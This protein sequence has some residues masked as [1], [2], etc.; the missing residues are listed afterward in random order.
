[1]LGISTTN[2]RVNGFRGLSFV[3]KIIAAFKARVLADSGTFEAESCLNTTVQDLVNKNL[4]DSASL[5]VTPN[6]VKAS[7]LYSIVP[8]SALGDMDV[9]RATTATRVNASGLIE[10]V[11]VNIPRIDYTNGSCPSLLVEPQ[12]TNSITYS[13]KFDDVSWLLT[14]ATI[15]GGILSPSGINNAWT[16]SN[17]APSGILQK[18]VSLSG[19]RTLTLY[20][21]Q[22]THRYLYMGGYGGVN[23]YANFDLLNGVVSSG[24]NATIKSVGNGWYCCTCNLI[25]G[26]TG[27]LQIF[28]SNNAVGNSTTNGS[29]YIWGAQLEAGSFATSYIP[30]VA[31]S[32]TRNTDMISKTEISSLIG[33]TEGTA[34][35]EGVLSPISS[36]NSLVSLEVKNS[37]FINLR[38][39]NLNKIEVGTNGLSTEFTIAS[40]N[41]ILSNT[42]YKVAFSYKSG[43][44]NLYIN[45]VLVA[46]NSVTYTIPALSQFKFNVWDTFD[47][48]KNIKTSV[49]WK[50]QLTDFELTTLTTS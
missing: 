4:Y 33:Q 20:A 10:S 46:S 11:G 2:L 13:E 45:G 21:K 29:I 38:V 42:F 44:N 12:R 49:I 34:Y 17:T 25:S 28:P 31:A 3:K 27:G 30:T 5:I 24:A 47:E 37:V 22:G 7:K 32:V 43:K 18:A 39:N 16:L 15:T 50:T 36:Y 8:S 6:G 35:W 9:V 14:G 23:S 41:S 1:M 40:S 26:I 19:S 48:K